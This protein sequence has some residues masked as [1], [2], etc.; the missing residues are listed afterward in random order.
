MP[1]NY[2]GFV[3]VKE[4][5]PHFVESSDDSVID[6]LFAEY[7]KVIFKSFVT[8][9][10]LDMFIKDQYGGDVDTIHNVRKIGEDP[11]L[12]YKATGNKRAYDDRTPYSHDD[13]KFK[14]SNYYNMSKEAGKN[15]REGRTMKDEYEGKDVYFFNRSGLKNAPDK[16]ASIDHVIAGKDIYDDRGRVLAG[17]ST[18]E[19]ADAK[20]NL[21]WTNASLNS[22]MQDVDIPTYIKN[23]PELPEDT[24]ARMMDAYNQAVAEYERKIAQ[25]YYFDFSNPNC[26]KF[27]QEAA[28]SA[29]N[30]GLQMGLR[31]VIGCVLTEL[32]FSV[33]DEISN[34]DGSV[35]GVIDAIIAGLKKGE[36]HAKENYKDLFAQFGQGMLSGILSSVT[37]TLINTF[38]TTSQS[39]G[40]IIRQAWASTVEATSILLFNDKEQYFCD[41]MTS[42]AKVLAAGAGMIIGTSV[43]DAVR[44]KLTELSVPKELTDIVSLF[45]GGLCTGLLT[46][47]MLFYI[48]NDPYDK[49]LEHIYGR[50]KRNL[51]EQ[52]LLFK[53]YCAKLEQ[54]DVDR[55]E[56]QTAYVFALTIK[57]ENANDQFELN[58]LLW[59][60]MSDLG[61]DSPFGNRTL[62]DCMNDKDWVLTI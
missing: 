60:A 32:W 19:L 10:G 20:S 44:I 54:I 36:Q 33:K 43:Q 49:Y 61:I 50:N 37:T 55:L 57:L 41:R 62:N 34:S 39:T 3:F 5:G 48:D 22:K 46:V 2:S 9:F 24:K 11:N 56:S 23:H 40:R 58:R 51:K 25:A 26:R 42:A 13:L 52:G 30:R 45:A 7:E 14:G 17:L 18:E 35:K 47:T 21:R 1:D 27:Y 53:Q 29:A 59:Q 6:A 38:L 31:Q 4:I 8:A 15:R 28:L 16:A 12:D